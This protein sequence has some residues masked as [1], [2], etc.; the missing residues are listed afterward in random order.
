MTTL[1]S[2]WFRFV[3]KSCA[4]VAC[5]AKRKCRSAR[6]LTTPHSA[7]P[8]YLDHLPIRD[9]EDVQKDLHRFWDVVLANLDVVHRVLA[10]CVGIEMSSDVF[11][12]SLDLY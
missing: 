1:T 10:Q 7:L 6:A 12:L 4:C 9:E 3:C 5:S 2:A 8:E 11:N